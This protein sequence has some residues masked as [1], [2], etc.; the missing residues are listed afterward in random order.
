MRSSRSNSERRRL[1]LSVKRVAEQLPHIKS[2]TEAAP[3]DRAPPRRSAMCRTWPVR[4]RLRRPSVS[5]MDDL[6]AAVADF[7]SPAELETRRRWA[8]A[9]RAGSRDRGAAERGDRHSVTETELRGR[10]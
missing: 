5:G 2:A 8:A 3:L 7:G 10:R 9:R 6:R 1:S 4:R